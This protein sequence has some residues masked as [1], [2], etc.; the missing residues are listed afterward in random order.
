MCETHVRNGKHFSEIVLGGIM[1]MVVGD[2][3]GVPVEFVSR[4]RLKEEPVTDMREYGSHEQP[5]GTWSDD[6]SMAL[7]LLDSLM[8]GVDYNDICSKFLAWVN[9][10]YMTAHGQIFD[11]GRTTLAALRSYDKGIPPLECG[12]SS[13]NDNGNGSLMRILPVAFY[14]MEMAEKERFELAHNISK[15][16]H[17]HM[18][19]MMA[20]GCC[21]QL[22]VELI[23]GGSKEE[24]HRHMIEVCEDYYS[25]EE[26]LENFR[27]ILDEKI[28]SLRE[29]A[30]KSSGY[31]IDTLEAAIWCLLTT[32]NYKECVLKAVNLGEDTD[33]T[34]AVAGG[35]AGILYGYEGI[36]EGWKAAVAKRE[37][38]EGLCLRFGEGHTHR[39]N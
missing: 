22:A 15:L 28:G 1:G 32:E 14:A 36:P 6:S 39:H 31:V 2:A 8:N 12:R 35:L 26:E 11:I 5:K 24:A 13:E 25:K 4:N 18:R 30:V 19:S 21:V 3:L 16:T 23:K 33:T 38:I 9:E 10:G 7:C 17:G 34:A 20:C 37:E 27:R 29:E